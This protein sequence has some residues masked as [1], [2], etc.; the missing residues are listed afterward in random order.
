MDEWLLPIIDL[1]CCTNCGLCVTLCPT[2]AVALVGGR[3]RIV[4]PQDCSYCATCEDACPESA[5]AL[6]YEIVP[7]PHQ[8]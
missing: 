3:P 8:N 1:N 4:R 6:V 2:H 7:A 5:I